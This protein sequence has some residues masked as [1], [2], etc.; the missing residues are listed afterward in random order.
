MEA[1]LNT[2]MECFKLTPDTRKKIEVG[3]CILLTSNIVTER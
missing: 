1:K 2:E 3:L